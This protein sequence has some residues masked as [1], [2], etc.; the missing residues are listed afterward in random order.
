VYAYPFRGYWEDIGTIKAFFEANLD[1]TNPMPKFNLYDPVAP[2]YTHA[3]YLPAS[4]INQSQISQ[5][6]V[7]EGCIITQADIHHS[8]VGIRSIIR[9]ESEINDCILMGNDYYETPEEMQ[10]NEKAGVPHLGIGRR[11][12]LERCIVDKNARIGDD[13]VI[14]PE[15]KPADAKHALYHLRDGIIVIPKKTVI[16]S[17]TT[18]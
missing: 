16:P 18:I 12:R 10:A 13:V 11:C 5:S 15:G 2:I 4:K 6:I 9:R 7:S 17:G 3:R 1:L 8:V 14:S